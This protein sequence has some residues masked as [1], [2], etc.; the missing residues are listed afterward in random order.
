[1]RKPALIILALVATGALT[2]IACAESDRIEL[3]NGDVLR[4]RIVERTDMVIVLEHASL[5]RVEIPRD[6]IA[7]MPEP[8]VPER[9]VVEPPPF[10]E[11]PASPWESQLDV[12][13][14]GS[15]GNSDTFDA[16]IGFLTIN[17]TITDRWKIDAAYYYGTSGSETNKH[18]FTSGVLKDWLMPDSPWLLFAQGRYDFDQFKTWRHRAT[19]HG[20][21]G[22][23][24]IKTDELTLIGRIGAGVAQ[25]W[26]P[27]SGPRP[28]GLLG[29]EVIWNISDRQR[30]V[31]HTTLY[32][33]L[34]DFF[35][36]RV[37]SG[38]A[39]TM[40]L[41]FAKGLAFTIG[42]DN[43]YESSTAPGIRH[44]DLKY[45]AGLSLTF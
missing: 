3:A 15:R 30:L 10:V 1:M 14:A 19:G 5:G 45:F 21:A 24:F 12:G 23:E 2:V 31:A 29:G 26:K 39:W 13:V 28:E 33:D 22:Y 16:R 9:A 8:A 25:E 18:S 42:V 44:N 6:S 4:G 11:P 17:E 40:S 43:E 36:F 7:A 34:G 27:T 38:L 32:P 35:E 37:V 41:D 20:G